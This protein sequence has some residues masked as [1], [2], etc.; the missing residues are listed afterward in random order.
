MRGSNNNGTSTEEAL[1]GMLITFYYV[2]PCT[3][4]C[5]VLLFSFSTPDIIGIVIDNLKEKK[6][7][8][9]T[10]S[11][12]AYD[13]QD[14]MCYDSSC[15]TKYDSISGQ[16]RVNPDNANAL[17]TAAASGCVSVGVSTGTCGTSIDY[18]VLVVGYATDG[19]LK[20]HGVVGV[21]C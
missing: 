14:G 1:F 19:D 17:E 7:G 12:C 8:L 11:E 3:N 20:I 16:T 5:V 9:C 2:H 15:G 13:A 18:G 6:G 10:E 4:I 21:M